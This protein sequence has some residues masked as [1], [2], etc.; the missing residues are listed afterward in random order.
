MI[1]LATLQPTIDDK[2]SSYIII[3]SVTELYKLLSDNTTANKVIISKDFAT[4]FFTQIG[5]A[6]V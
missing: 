6:H 4:K 3:K 5:R 1:Y 2:L